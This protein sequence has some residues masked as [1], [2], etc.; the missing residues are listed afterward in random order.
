MMKECSGIGA[1]QEE[2]GRPRK[3][4]KGQVVG[5]TRTIRYRLPMN[6][7]SRS[8]AHQTAVGS[9]IRELSG[10]RKGWLPVRTWAGEGQSAHANQPASPV[11]GHEQPAGDEGIVAWEAQGIEFDLRASTRGQQPA[12]SASSSGGSMLT[13]L[14]LITP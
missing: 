3:Q 6:R 1:L 5:V 13:S 10:T 12:A 2:E 7:V 9:R 8:G 11:P 14:S 4:G